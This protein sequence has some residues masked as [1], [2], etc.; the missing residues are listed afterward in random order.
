MTAHHMGT[1]Q[2]WK[3]ETNQIRK[4][5]CRRKSGTG[6]GNESTDGEM[7]GTMRRLANV[8]IS[9]TN[10][11]DGNA[12]I[13]QEGWAPAG[14]GAEGTGVG[15]QHEIW[16]QQES[17]PQATSGLHFNSAVTPPAFIAG[18]SAQARLKMTAV[19]F[20]SPSDQPSAISSGTSPVQ[21]QN[22]LCNLCS[23]FSIPVLGR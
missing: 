4:L 22:H 12:L 16:T 13:S 19:Q 5:R 21:H 9:A 2:P 3:S 8:K 15:M 1:P 11:G 7:A 17:V 18:M 14:V 20:I 23:R 10:F 6:S